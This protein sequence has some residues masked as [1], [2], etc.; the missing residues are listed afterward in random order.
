MK[1]TVSVLAALMLCA[2][3]IARAEEPTVKSLPPSIVKTVPEC[4]DINVDAVATTQIKVTFSKPMMDGSWSWAQFS[5]DTFPPMIGKPR[6][7]DDRKT[8]VLDVKLQPKKT[9]VIWLNSQKFKNFKDVDGQSAVPY[10]LVF[11]T[12]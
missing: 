9:Y 6:Y 12:R 10:L 5:D 3:G 7:L 8:C 1:A 2:V 11:E 4:G